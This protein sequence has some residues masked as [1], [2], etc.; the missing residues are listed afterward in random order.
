MNILFDLDGTLADPFVGITKSM[1]YALEK[2]GRPVPTLESLRWCIGPPLRGNFSKLLASE[3]A[4]LVEKA[5]ALYRERFAPIG[6]WEN[7]MYA[8]IPEALGVL[9]GLGHTLY[10]ATSKPTVYAEPIME[11]FGLRQFF[12]RIYGSELDG[13][14]SD[15]STLIGY[16]LQTESM[17]SSE[18]VMVGDREH[19][20]IG[21]RGNGLHSIGVLWGYGTQEELEGAGASTCVSSPNELVSAVGGVGSRD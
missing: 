6:L 15:K 21:A 11:R 1:S 4:E 20:I 5:V 9:K 17:T 14:R 19:D 2:L 8:G 16:I 10:I 13:T 3:D 7:E 18:T 12:R